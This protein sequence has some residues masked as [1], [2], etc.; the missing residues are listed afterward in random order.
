MFGVMFMLS[1]HKQQYG[2]LEL[3]LV[4]RAYLVFTPLGGAGLAFAVSLLGA[5]AAAVLPASAVAV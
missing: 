5:A 4:W 3:C 1:Q 2:S